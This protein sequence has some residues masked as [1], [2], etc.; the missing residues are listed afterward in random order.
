MSNNPLPFDDILRPLVRAAR[1][2]LNASGAPAGLLLPPA[3]A[4]L[5]HALLQRLTRW[6]APV[7]QVDFAAFRAYERAAGSA[8]ETPA[9]STALYDRFVREMSAGRWTVVMRRHPVL[10]RLLGTISRQWTDATAEMLRRL[11]AD[12]S[13]LAAAIDPALTGRVAAVR[14]SLSDPHHDGRT[15]AILTLEGG[16]EVAYKPRCVRLARAFGKGVHWLSGRDGL[17]SLRAPRVLPG[18]SGGSSAEEAYGWME[19]V[20]LAP[21]PHPGAAR[22]YYRRF[23]AT[24]ALL[25]LLGGTDVHSGN[26]IACGAHPQIV[27]LEG[28]LHPVLEV[29][30]APALH[31][32]VRRRLMESVLQTGL[33]PR[34]SL[35]PEGG[36]FDVSGLSAPP[37]PETSG[38]SA[39]RVLGWTG[40]GTD[41]MARAWQPAPDPPSAHRPMVDGHAV[42]ASDHVGALTDGF[43]CAYD[44][45]RHHRQA[46]SAADGPLAAFGEGTVRVLV[47]NTRTYTSVMRRAYHPRFLH[48]ETAASAELD[49][50]ARPLL[51]D[52]ADPALRPL[53]DAERADLA[54]LDVPVFT[55]RPAETTLRHRGRPLIPD[56]VATAPLDALH[57]RLRRLCTGDRD[58]QLRLIRGAL[59]A[60]A[61]P[62]AALP[63]APLSTGDANGGEPVAP[64]PSPIGDS[65]SWLE[66]A[67]FVAGR[68]RHEALHTPE[69]ATW[70]HLQHDPATEHRALVPMDASLYR[71]VTGVAVFLAAFARVDPAASTEARE[72]AYAALAPVRATLT[73]SPLPPPA[74]AL[75]D[76]MGV[77][78]G[79]GLG[80]VVYGLCLAGRLL[81]DDALLEDAASVAALLTP[82][83][84]EAAGADVIS[85]T[86]GALL[87]LLALHAATGDAASLQRARTAGDVLLRAQTGDPG[88]PGAWAT[89][90]GVLRTGASHGAAGIAA[91]LNRLARAT[92]RARYD[93]A[94]A[95]ALRFERTCYDPDA[96]TWRPGPNL[97]HAD[98]PQS[99]WCHAPPGF[100]LARLD[101]ASSSGLEDSALG[102]SALGDSA[103]VDGDGMADLDAALRATLAL[104]TSA[105]DSLCC[106]TAGRVDALLT[107][108][109]VL[110]RPSL[111]DAARRRAAVLAHRTRSGGLHLPPHSGVLAPGLFQGISGAGYTCLRLLAPTV[112]PSVLRWEIGC[113]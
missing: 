53:L 105:P 94:A 30:E 113:S 47:R 102:D 108:G 48:A 82:G 97:S 5:E 25:Y 51:R 92:G 68:L 67:R 81:G 31:A 86:A 78:G 109:R 10:A 66:A 56:A 18:S 42:P 35:R 38:P 19:V 45:L 8:S 24:L 111:V 61:L 70:L 71:G 21:C 40:V 23:G 55:M 90:D 22:T 39:P 13:R 99:G 95:R 69:G 104:G 60:A 29:Q 72:L 6:A 46:L 93:R 50:L 14:P 76:A 106:G 107:A 17:P 91:A 73:A 98:A 15:V 103:W 2:G 37:S 112:V 85:G 77:G 83:R 75:V 49:V 36:A 57:A 3:R 16:G 4:A 33:L 43:R 65:S 110:H 52:T 12:R 101:A 74:R 96:R 32:S 62:A 20:A 7:L 26:V 64:S 28:L 11:E 89:I 84:L 79:T 54:R 41:A 9:G 100:A 63:T 27:D 34:W 87:A 58:F 88:G 59:S 44:V 80:S 1:S